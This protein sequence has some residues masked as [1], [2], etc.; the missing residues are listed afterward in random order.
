MSEFAKRL[1]TE[2]ERLGLTPTAFGCKAGVGVRLQTQYEG[3]REPPLPYLLRLDDMGV[4][5]LYL[6]TGRRCNSLSEL[7]E[8]EQFLLDTYRACDDRAKQLV[9]D[10]VTLLA[11]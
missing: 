8:R 4:D 9:L 3:K 5:V 2:R 10:T 1:G 7:S 11:R 6:L